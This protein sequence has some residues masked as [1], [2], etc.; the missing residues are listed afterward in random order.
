MPD[1]S[2]NTFNDINPQYPEDT[3]L[4]GYHAA[5]MRQ[6]K[7]FLKQ[8]EGLES[9]ISEWLTSSESNI[10]SEALKNTYAFLLLEKSI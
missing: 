4:A 7:R 6:V 5:A 3:E 9:I 1:Y 2:G 8:P 10:I